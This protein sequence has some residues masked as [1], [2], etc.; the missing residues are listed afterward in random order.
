MKEPDEIWVHVDQ[1]G[2]II[3]YKFG[4]P[5]S[6]ASN[7]FPRMAETQLSILRHLTRDS[8]LRCLGV[9]MDTA[10]LYL[11]VIRYLVLPQTIPRIPR[12]APTLPRSV[13]PDRWIVQ[14][15]TSCP[16]TTRSQSYSCSTSAETPNAVPH[17]RWRC[18]ANLTTCMSSG[19]L[20]P[21]Q[22]N[23]VSGWTPG[24]TSGPCTFQ[25]SVQSEHCA[26]SAASVRLVLPALP[27]QCGTWADRGVYI[28]F[29]IEVGIALIVAEI[30]Q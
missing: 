29:G 1:S 28:R 18:P 3:L 11:V 4:H 12:R 23:A 24:F 6:Q 14:N 8:G 16:I 20:G 10:G 2:L 15:N 19:G 22:F 9:E 30:K 21:R 17:R 7:L 13:F 25:E 26:V 5:P 27:S